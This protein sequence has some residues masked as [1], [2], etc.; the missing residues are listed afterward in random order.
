MARPAPTAAAPA[1]WS[2]LMAD[3]SRLWADAGLV[4][5]LRS[6]QMMGGG[7]AAQRE[8][9]RMFN[10]KIAAGFELAGA[11][12]G[13]GMTSPEAATRKALGVYGKRVRGNR[14]RLS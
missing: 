14:K 2:R 4:V 13:G 1:D 5:A 12:A 6:W 11:L 3:A 7:P 8:L 10:E 9:E